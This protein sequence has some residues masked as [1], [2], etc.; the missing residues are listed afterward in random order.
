M[1]REIKITMT[2]TEEKAAAAASTAAA[3]LGRRRWEGVSPEERSKIATWVASHGAGRPRSKARRCPC[4]AM[5]LKLAKIRAGA[6]GTGLGH[7]PGC[8]FYRADRLKVR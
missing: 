1:R 7:K 4:G 5:T 3:A 8:L 6:S 2:T